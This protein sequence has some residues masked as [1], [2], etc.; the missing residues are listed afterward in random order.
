LS[1]VEQVFYLDRS[2]CVDRFQFFTGLLT[3]VIKRYVQPALGFE[4]PGKKKPEPV[5][6]KF[7][8]ANT[9]FWCL[10]ENVIENGQA[11]VSAEADVDARSYPRRHGDYC[12][13]GVPFDP[14]IAGKNDTHWWHNRIT[15]EKP[16]RE[17]MSKVAAAV[18]PAIAVIG[19]E[20]DVVT[21]D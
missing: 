16:I 10:E 15:E 9:G 19:P 3:E 18:I 5:T 7:R 2:Y 1:E 21:F 11:F 4:V 20:V 14:E 13:C 8:V 17:L 6:G 12:I